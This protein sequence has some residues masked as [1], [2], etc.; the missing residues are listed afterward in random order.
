MLNIVPSLDTGVCARSAETFDARAA[1]V[2]DAV[3][4]TISKD[5]PFAQKRFCTASDISQVVTLSAM[6]DTSFGTEYGVTMMDGPMAG[7]FARA[8]VVLDAEDKVVYTQLVP[9]IA[10]EPDYASALDALAKA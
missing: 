2:D 8:V 1:E 5:L 6:R 3:F 10:Q 9:E 7:I 4:L